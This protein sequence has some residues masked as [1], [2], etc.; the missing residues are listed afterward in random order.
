MD[1][2]MAQSCVLVELLK[3][4]CIGLLCIQEDSMDTN[5]PYHPFLLC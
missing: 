1:P 2:I 4:I 3:F 5:L